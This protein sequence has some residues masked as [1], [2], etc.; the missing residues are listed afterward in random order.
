M[1]TVGWHSSNIDIAG[2]AGEGTVSR[3]GWSPGFWL[4]LF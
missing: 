3:K 4:K 1:Y 2:T